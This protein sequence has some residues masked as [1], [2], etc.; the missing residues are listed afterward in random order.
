M[1]QTNV[2]PSMGSMEFKVAVIRKQ[3][4]KNDIKE[5]YQTN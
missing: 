1:K 2:P 3:Q 5:G 4:L